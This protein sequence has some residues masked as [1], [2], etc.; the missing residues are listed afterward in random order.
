MSYPAIGFLPGRY[1]TPGVTFQRF[2][3]GSMNTTGALQ[4]QDPSKTKAHNV[5]YVN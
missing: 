2:P 1:V 3:F 4:N 5:Y